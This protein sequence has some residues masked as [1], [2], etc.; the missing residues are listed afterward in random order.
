MAAKN[1]QLKEILENIIHEETQF[2]DGRNIAYVT[3]ARVGKLS[4]AG[5]LDFGGSEYE[6]ADVDWIEP[7]PRSEDDKY[8]WYDLE[9]GSY[10]IEFNESI[11]LP[12]D[13]G[14]LLQIW[15]QAL[16]NGVTHPTEVLTQSRKP[17]FTQIHVSEAGI[18][19]KENARFSELR[20]L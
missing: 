12:D 14:V 17:L 2:P 18:H 11:D 16:K 13:T 10:R 20:L 9:Q 6:E 3:V 5:S 4:G 8:G 19:I 1:E 15:D 7:K